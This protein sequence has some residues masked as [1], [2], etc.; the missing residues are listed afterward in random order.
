[1]PLIANSTRLDSDVT[2]LSSGVPT[3]EALSVLSWGAV[4]RRKKL[5][6]VRLKLL[7]DVRD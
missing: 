5:D 2:L 3:E 4:V 1:M 6:I 7:V